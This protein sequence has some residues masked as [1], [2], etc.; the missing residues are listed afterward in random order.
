LSEKLSIRNEIELKAALKKKIEKDVN[1]EKLAYDLRGF[2]PEQE[3]VVGFSRNYKEI[4]RK[5]LE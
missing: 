5:Y 3:F 1:E 4:M 2:F